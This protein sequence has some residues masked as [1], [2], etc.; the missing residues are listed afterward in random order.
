MSIVTDGLRSDKWRPFAKQKLQMLKDMGLSAKNYV[1]DG[2]RI[3]LS[4]MDGID[5]ARITAPP[6]AVVVDFTGGNYEYRYCDQYGGDFALTMTRPPA[7]GNSPR[8]LFSG[9]GDLMYHGSSDFF[10]TLGQYGTQ[11]MSW[12]APRPII[13]ANPLDNTGYLAGKM[14]QH[15]TVP[16]THPTVGLAFTRNGCLYSLAAPVADATH[17]FDGV[18]LT[19]VRA[20]AAFV[21]GLDL[22]A[23][24]TGFRGRAFFARP[25]W[26]ENAAMMYVFHHGGACSSD[27]GAVSVL[28]YYQETAVDPFGAGGTWFSG[29]VTQGAIATALGL[30]VPCVLGNVE[31]VSAMSNLLGPDWPFSAAPHQRGTFSHGLYDVCAWGPVPSGGIKGVVFSFDGTVEVL[32]IALPAYDSATQRPII[33]EV[34]PGFYVCEVWNAAA[35]ELAAVYY[36]SPFDSW[37]EFAHPD[38][39]ILRHK[40]IEASAGGVKALALMHADDTTTLHEYDGAWVARGKVADGKIDRADVAVFGSHPFARM[41]SMDSPVRGVWM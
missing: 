1:I 20:A 2:C 38:G 39:L 41:A 7:K 27:L 16:A 9:L 32:D 3:S 14:T 40:T 30:P 18:V 37:T 5:K 28:A 6:G 34:S 11:A 35:F 36:G 25:V 26:G 31:T 22:S 33:A 15:E 17:W 8:A 24:H 29:Q 23:A 12:Y 10:A 19:V 4:T 21:I 13:A